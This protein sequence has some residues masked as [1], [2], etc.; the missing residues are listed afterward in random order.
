MS[1]APR[2]A[3]S[4]ETIDRDDL[5]CLATIAQARLATAFDRL[6]ERKQT[7]EKGLLAIC[8]CQGAA[9]HCVDPATSAGVHDFDLW[10]FYR[11]PP[12]AKPLWNR[13][14]FTADFGPSKFGR[15]PLDTNRYAGRRVDVLWRDIP[16]GEDA[17]AAVYAYFA[18]PRTASARALRQKSVVLVWP[19]AHV[20]DVI[21]RG[22]A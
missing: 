18:T 16:A 21:W 14:P 22:V 12:G 5:Q 17:F 2:A 19:T 6:P 3:R 8:L 15:S 20:G 10:A 7:H 1:L 11:R 4:F 13:Q 9:D